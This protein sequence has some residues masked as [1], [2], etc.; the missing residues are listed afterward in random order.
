MNA[1]L[2]KFLRDEDG[3]TAI[4]YGL[5]AGLIAVAIIVAVTSLGT[6]V[7]SVFTRI[8]GHLTTVGS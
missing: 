3:V 4:E 8:A 2:M 6:N 5:I 1:K 7:A